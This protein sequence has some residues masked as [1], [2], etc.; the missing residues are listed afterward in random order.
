MQTKLA[1]LCLALF[2]CDN[3]PADA[4]GCDTF[5]F[6]SNF[7]P[8][9]GVKL[10]CR[11]VYSDTESE[12]QSFNEYTDGRTTVT[13]WANSSVVKVTGDAPACMLAAYREDVPRAPFTIADCTVTTFT[14]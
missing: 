11:L 14:P 4:M 1:L 5:A 13:Y 9:A 8:T 6:L 12:S 10:E 7:R 3:L 2:G